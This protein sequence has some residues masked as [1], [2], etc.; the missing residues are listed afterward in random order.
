MLR[1]LSDDIQILRDLRDEKCMPKW[2]P[3]PRL[4]HLPEKIRM[5]AGMMEQSLRLHEILECFPDPEAAL[6]QSP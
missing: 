4:A 1:T 5:I 2:T 6:P 3:D